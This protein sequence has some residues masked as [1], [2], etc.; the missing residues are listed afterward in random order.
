MNEVPCA[1]QESATWPI[2]SVSAVQ[3]HVRS[4]RL[5]GSGP[6]QVK[7]SDRPFSDIVNLMALRVA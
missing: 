3:R 2:A 6:T 5:S 7:A 1:A 4:W